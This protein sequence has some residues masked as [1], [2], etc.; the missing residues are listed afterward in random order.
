[1]NRIVASILTISQHLVTLYREP[2][3]YRPNSCPH[4]CFGKL[5][6]HGCYERKADRESSGLKS[7][8]PVAIPR[9]R[10][11]GCRKTCS[12]LPECI[13][14][15]RWYSWL[16]QHLVIGL[17][18]SG[19]SIRKSAQQCGLCRKT[20]RRWRRWLSER[21]S[22]FAFVLRA[23]FPEWGR[24]VDFAGFWRNALQDLSLGRMMLWLDQEGAVVP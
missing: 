16:I 14:P 6:N 17:W 5:W 7:L 21:H 3:V 19:F 10:C 11:L 15:R 9:Y 1:M 22:E 2:L 18:L 23:R 24:Q 20:V 8:N 13:A 4:C 12:R